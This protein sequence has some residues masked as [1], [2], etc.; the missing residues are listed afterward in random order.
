MA[1]FMGS[2]EECVSN[3]ASRFSMDILRPLVADFCAVVEPTARD[4]LQGNRLPV[5]EPLIRLRVF[6][7]LTDYRVDEL[8]ELNINLRRLNQAIALGIYTPTQ[9]QET[10]GYNNVQEVYRVVLRG[11]GLKAKRA[12]QLERLLGDVEEDINKRFARWQ[13][14]I[15]DTLHTESARRASPART[16]APPET[17]GFFGTSTSASVVEHLVSAL[18]NLLDNGS[19]EDDASPAPLPDTARKAIYDLVGHDR[20]RRLI[21]QLEMLQ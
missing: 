4:W 9:V 20:L 12:L 18:S 16:S 6:L 14:R 7:H 5:G 3:L 15:S 13:A 21:M 11:S 19:Q 10:L 17:S 1:S 8:D 2:T